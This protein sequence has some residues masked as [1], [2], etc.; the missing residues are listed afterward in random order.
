MR[1]KIEKRTEISFLYD[2]SKEL[3]KVKRIEESIYPILKHLAEY[4]G[5]SCCSLTIIKSKCHGSILEEFYGLNQSEISNLKVH[6]KNL[7]AKIIETGEPMIVPKI[8][9]TPQFIK[10]S[11]DLA[12]FT[13]EISLI[14]VPIK[15]ASSVL[16]FFAF[17]LEFFESISFKLE[18]RILNIIGSMLAHSIIAS[19]EKVDEINLLKREN[20]KLQSELTKELKNN[21][22]IGNASSIQAVFELV[23]KVAKTNATVL[24]RG[25]S[26]VG[27]ELVA[28]AIHNNSPRS[29]K[30]LIK[31]NCSALPDSLIESELFGHEKGAFTA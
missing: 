10:S 23:R 8:S 5:I 28:N 14:C 12:D 11:R 9:H 3:Q 4:I 21:E 25:E 20:Q 30:P 19:Q 31:V 7:S 15:A 6:L 27:K 16:G 22:I 29:E 17:S 18:F 24:L 2:I 26:G 13:Y 1:D